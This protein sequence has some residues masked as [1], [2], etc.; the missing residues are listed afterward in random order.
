MS[1]YLRERRFSP[2][3]VLLFSTFV[4]ATKWGTPL[5]LSGI[6]HVLGVPQ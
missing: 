2:L 3:D 6:A 5:L 4:A 1:R